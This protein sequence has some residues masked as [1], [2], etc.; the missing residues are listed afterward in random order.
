MEGCWFKRRCQFSTARAGQGLGRSVGWCSAAGGQCKELLKTT[1]G[2]MRMARPRSN[3]SSACASIQRDHQF[4]AAPLPLAVLGF[5]ICVGTSKGWGSVFRR[6]IIRNIF[7]QLLHAKIIS[8][9]CVTGNSGP[10]QHCI[11]HTQP[12]PLCWAGAPNKR[13]NTLIIANQ[14]ER[15]GLALLCSF[16]REA[17]TCAFS[18]QFS[19]GL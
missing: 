8:E 4:A 15:R 1:D 12:N 11:A 17:A 13:P 9:G 19:L 5:F 3:R 2:H 14:I 16:R 18:S 7:F 6:T 10:A